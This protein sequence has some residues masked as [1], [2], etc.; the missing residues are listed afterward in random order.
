MNNIPKQPRTDRIRVHQPIKESMPVQFFFV[1]HS[2]LFNGNPSMHAPRRTTCMN[3]W[4]DCFETPLDDHCSDSRPDGNM[5]FCFEIALAGSKQATFTVMLWASPKK[6]MVMPPPQR[7][8]SR[9]RG[10]LAAFA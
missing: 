8:P 1:E 2:M 9:M 6:E 4:S 5:H 3:A 10:C 7:S